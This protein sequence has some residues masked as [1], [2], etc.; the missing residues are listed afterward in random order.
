MRLTNQKEITE[1]LIEVRDSP[2]ANPLFESTKPCVWNDVI[3]IIHSFRF[4]RNE[5]ARDSVTLINIMRSRYMGIPHRT[6]IDL[7][8]A[9]ARQWDFTSK[10][11]DID[12]CTAESVAD[13]VARY[14]KF[15]MLMEDNPKSILVPILSIDLAWH[16]H[17]LH[18]YCYREYTLKTLFRVINHDD[19]ITNQFVHNYLILTAK[20]WYK[21][22]HEPY[23]TDNLEKLYFNENKF[24]FFF[25]P[26]SIYYVMQQRK[27]RKAWQSYPGNSKKIDPKSVFHI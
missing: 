6:S 19:T 8:L 25:P 20:K 7:M 22:Y 11:V 4:L 5:R 24:A 9:V 17:M 3:K 14:K 15:L 21:K 27:L 12:W 10:M 16:T 26:T 18:H 2:V 13:A 1:S 23:T